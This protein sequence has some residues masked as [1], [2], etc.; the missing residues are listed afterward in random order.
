VRLLLVRH[1]ETGG[2]V[3]RRLQGPD[4]PLTER[5]RRQARE[6]AAH[7]CGRD[8]V[9]AL[10]TSPYPRALETA[11][12]IGGA[13][14]M[15]PVPR[16]GL[17]EMDVGK[18]A[19]YRFEDWAQKFPEEAERFRDEGVDYAWPGG[20][21]GRQLAT[22]AAAEVDRI[23]ESHGRE[24]GAVVVVSHGG[25][26]AWVISYLL[27]ESGEE[28]PYHYAR[29]DNCSITEVEVPSDGGPAKLV[30]TNEVG[31]LSPDPD[32]EAATGHEDP[33]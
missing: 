1:G 8:D 17:A 28:W 14:G 9:L 13:L 5:G 3:E 24:P 18:A 15:E 4:D 23:L 29:L 12:A 22:R 30:S 10:Y 7:L 27:R 2:N 32:A 21:S 6:L 19:G 11:R 16:A 25:A 20:E 26:L 33:G 31:H